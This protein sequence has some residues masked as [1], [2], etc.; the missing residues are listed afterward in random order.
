MDIA[1]ALLLTALVWQVIDFLRDLANLSTERSSVVTQATAWIGGVIV[2]VLAAHA[3]LFDSFTVNGITLTNLDGASQ[4][5][6]GLC[7]ASLASS[8]VDLKQAFDGSDS[9]KVPPLL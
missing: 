3:E 5:F 2:V 9:S 8:A 4:V 1:P 7:V 6:L